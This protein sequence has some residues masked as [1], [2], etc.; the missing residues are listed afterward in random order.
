MKTLRTSRNS[1]R[2]FWS[3]ARL[4]VKKNVVYLKYMIFTCFLILLFQKNDGCDYIR[5][6]ENMLLNETNIILSRMRRPSFDGD[7]TTSHINVKNIAKSI[8]RK[9]KT[10]LK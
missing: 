5:W 10:K 1:D 8:R 7:T 3:C 6:A 2:K 9:T 4:K